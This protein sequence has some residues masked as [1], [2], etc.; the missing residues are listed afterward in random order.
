MLTTSLSAELLRRIPLGRSAATDDLVV[1][2][3]L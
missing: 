3:V 2:L 1:L